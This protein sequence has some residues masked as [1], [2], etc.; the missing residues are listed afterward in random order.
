MQRLELM[1]S[2]LLSKLVVSVKLA[3]EKM[4][5]V[6]KVVRYPDSQIV[7]WWLRLIWKDWKLCAE[8]RVQIVAKNVALRNWFY[9]WTDSNP[10]D[11]ATRLKSLVCLKGC[12]LWWQDPEFLQRYG[13]VHGG[14]V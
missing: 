10:A 14:Q 5:K 4:L 13:Y 9:V 7:L 3:V 6:T 12:L 1:G 2:V 8:N 11:L